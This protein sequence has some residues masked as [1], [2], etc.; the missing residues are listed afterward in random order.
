MRTEEL[1]R[2]S[3]GRLFTVEFIKRNGELRK[4]RAR[5]HAPKSFKFK[6]TGMRYDPLARGLLPVWDVDKKAFRMVNLAT[7][8]RLRVGGNNY[9]FVRSEDMRSMELYQR[10]LR[11]SRRPRRTTRHRRQ[12]FTDQ[13]ARNVDDVNDCRNKKRVGYI[14]L[15]EGEGWRVDVFADKTCK[16]GCTAF[17]KESTKNVYE[18]LS[19]IF[20]S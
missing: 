20:K 9:E 16:V 2:E 1:I 13:V 17:G 7:I 10:Q 18:L 19:L 6:G 5:L 12:S 11:D 14:H 4:M 8:E 3:N 15:P